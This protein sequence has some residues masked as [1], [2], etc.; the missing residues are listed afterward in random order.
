[1][2]TITINKVLIII[3]AIAVILFVIF[4]FW[5]ESKEI[6]II[7]N[8][9]IGTVD[10]GLPRSPISGIPCENADR[11]P[12]SVMIAADP[13]TRP[14]SGINEADMVFEM[15]VT[16]NGIT[17]F[18]AVFQ[19]NDPAEIGSIRSARNDFIP[20]AYGLGSIYVHWGG[21]KEALGKL[22][23]HIMDNINAMKYEGT[24]FYRKK[25]IPMPHNGFTD[26]GKIIDQ[27]KKLG[28]GLE[29]T[30]GGYPHEEREIKKNLSNIADEINIEYPR[31]YD[32]K[33]IYDSQKDEYKRYRGGQ[34]EM[35]RN[36]NKQVSARVVAIVKTT[37]KYLSKDYIAIETQGNG[38]AIIYQG[39]VSFPAK[40]RKDRSALDSKLYF[41]DND[42]EEVKFLPGKI[43]VEIIIE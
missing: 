23:N 28:Y 19:C 13:E 3:G 40:W 34:P 41:Y 29:N 37:S 35:D 16:P 43:W 31:P 9:D 25:G 42:G 4:W 15:P 6:N 1:M 12:I 39:G 36:T 38:E 22:E 32:V 7:G 14:L 18:M 17:R 33:W 21:E 10:N 30:F 8:Q 26:I 2:T 11:R 27:A 5:W 24:V 20:L